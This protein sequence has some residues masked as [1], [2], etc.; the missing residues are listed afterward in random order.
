MY[1]LLK[2]FVSLFCILFLSLSANAGIKKSSPSV[3][4]S[5]P[6]SI[7]KNQPKVKL[8]KKTTQVKQIPLSIQTIALKNNTINVTIA[9]TKK[10]LPADYS[11]V[12]LHVTAPKQK[13]GKK[14][15]LQKVDLKRSLFRS[16][17][18]IIFNTKISLSAPGVV[19]A[20]LSKGKWKSSKTKSLI[21]T[22]TRTARQNIKKKATTKK[23]PT[24]KT[25]GKTPQVEPGAGKPVVPMILKDTARAPSSRVNSAGRE[26]VEASAAAGDDI[27]RDMG[28]NISRPVRGH[29]FGQRD[30]IDVRYSVTGE[31]EPGEITFRLM[32]GGLIVDTKT[33]TYS[34]VPE[35][36]SPEIVN[37]EWIIP[38]TAPITEYYYIHAIQTTTGAVG[39]GHYFAVTSRFSNIASSSR[40]FVL[41]IEIFEPIAGDDVTWGGSTQIRWTMPEE[42][43]PGNCGDRVS[44]YAI[45]EG[46]DH[47]IDIT[48]TDADPGSN[49]WEWHV[50]PDTIDPGG[51]YQIEIESTEGCKIKGSAFEV[52]SCDYAVESVTFLDGNSLATGID[53]R[54]GSVI[55]GGFRVKVRWNRIELPSIFAAGTE[56]G[57]RM[58]VRSKLTNEIINTPIE[59]SNFDY[60]TAIMA[61]SVGYIYVDI[62]FQFLRDDIA[63][64]MNNNR[65]IPLEFSFE[66]TGASVDT[67]SSNNR[68]DADMKVSFATVV[69]FQLLMSP[70]EFNIGRGRHLPGTAPIYDFNFTQRM[71]I[72]N[73][74][75]TVTGTPPADLFNVPVAWYIEW[76]PADADEY[77]TTPINSGRFL[78]SV[79]EA[80][81]GSPVTLSGRFSTTIN[82]PGRTYRIR[83]VVDPDHEYLD[84]DRV[85]NRSFFL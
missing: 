45:R 2:S 14:W 78:F 27:Y 71:D 47:R 16:T 54:D 80:D 15:V 69:N 52:K 19:K 23:M 43:E 46:T 29:D 30:T 56:W 11:G 58:T 41:P 39:F 65:N 25:L 10:L 57:N 75:T 85:S 44:I 72:R 50:N 40:N 24:M 1:N 84:P 77:I 22:R 55:S 17:K 42:D 68:L 20:T 74:A 66:P 67:I 7:Q 36:S 26:R 35:G 53:A 3:Q 70:H 73:V 21:P 81:F 59:G 38:A 28:I 13:T 34:P 63:H 31:L 49:S 82:H 5:P 32:R 60:T 48:Q 64:M 51:R 33:R 4:K 62:P 6:T 8:E 37:F 18:S 61:G 12:T 76:R 79:V 83:V 9:T